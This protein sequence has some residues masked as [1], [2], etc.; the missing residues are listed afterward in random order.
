[1]VI[2][3][4]DYSGNILRIFPIWDHF[5]PVQGEC[6]AAAEFRS[7]HSW[8]GLRLSSQGA[9][10]DRRAAAV[11]ESKKTQS[12]HILERLHEMCLCAGDTIS[13]QFTEQ[14]RAC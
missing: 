3:L 10:L 13:E 2:Y 12:L 5:N 11:S 1:M 14:P 8:L 4:K 6:R 9:V 7:P